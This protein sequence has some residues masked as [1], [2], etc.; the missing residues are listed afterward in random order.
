SET[1]APSPWSARTA[2]AVAG[3]QSPGFSTGSSSTSNPHPATRGAMPRSAA[4]VRGEVHTQ[5]LTPSARGRS[6]GTSD[7][8][9]DGPGR[10]DGAVG[11]EGATS[12]SL[13]RSDARPSPPARPTTRGAP[14]RGRCAASSGRRAGRPAGR[15]ATGRP[16]GGPAPR[17]RTE[18]LRRTLPVRGPRTGQRSV[19]APGKPGRSSPP[20]FA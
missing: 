17:G 1:L 20:N 7:P 10:A 12:L 15:T 9:G 3:S 8:S 14:P 6:G 11:A 16:L 5:V 18:V 4:S 2:A 13:V 19:Q